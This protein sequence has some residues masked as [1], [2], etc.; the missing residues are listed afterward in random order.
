MSV[1]FVEVFEVDTV[2][3]IYTFVDWIEEYLKWSMT[4]N[5]SGGT[6]VLQKDNF[7]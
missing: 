6:L 4:V 2:G 5:N 7:Y 1:I 3:V